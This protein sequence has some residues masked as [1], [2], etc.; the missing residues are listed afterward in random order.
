MASPDLAEFACGPVGVERRGGHCFGSAQLTTVQLRQRL[1]GAVRAAGLRVGLSPQRQ[2]PTKQVWGQ[3]PDLEVH[4]R[5][6]GTTQLGAAANKRSLTL[7]LSLE[8]RIG[9]V[10]IGM[11]ENI[12]LEK[13]IWNVERVYYIGRFE[14][15]LNDPVGR[16]HQ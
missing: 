10:F 7:D 11:R 5:V 4:H 12:T 2:V 1:T 14:A 13:E 8:N 6:V 3:C 16:N 9:I 15:I